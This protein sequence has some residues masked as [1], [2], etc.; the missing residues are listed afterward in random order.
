MF[1]HCYAFKGKGLDNWKLYSDVS[2]DHTFNMCTSLQKFP[3]WWIERLKG[4]V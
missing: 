3:Y 1:D 2:L 4:V